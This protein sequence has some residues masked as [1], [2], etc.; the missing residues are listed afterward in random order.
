VWARLTDHRVS[1]ALDGGRPRFHIRLGVAGRLVD[2]A[3][4]PLDPENPGDLRQ[5][6]DYLRLGEQ[7]RRRYPHVWRAIDWEAVFPQT[8][9]V[10]D[11]RAHGA[12]IESPGLVRWTVPYN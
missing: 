3:R 6:V 1:V 11:V 9:V 7:L 4:C 2:M 12:G 10:I 8:D 5:L